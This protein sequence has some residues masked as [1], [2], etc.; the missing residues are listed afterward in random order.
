MSVDIS[1]A[2]LLDV[3]S[4]EP[5][6]AEIWDAITEQQLKDWE[7]RWTPALLD[8]LKRLH[9]AGVPRHQ[10]PQ[11]KGWNWRR[12][13]QRAEGLLA[14]PGFSVICDGVTQGLMFADCAR[15][16][17]QIAEQANQHLV[18]VEFLE[19]APW[20][21]S[22]LLLTPQY[23]GVGSLL[24]RAAIQLSL[25][26]GFKG[27]LGLHSLPQADE[28][29]ARTCEMTDLGLDQ[30]K[31]NL[32]YFEMTPLQAQAFIRKGNSK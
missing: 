6:R 27:R 7:G 10:W 9:K 22:E 15:H 29:Y 24:I 19:N 23:R 3:T 18:Y 5:V 8:G 12:K 25:D 20:N 14:T 1:P 21:Q 11:S 2:F 26:E 32:R 31:E 28:W 13:A 30:S 17:C 4:G 16:R